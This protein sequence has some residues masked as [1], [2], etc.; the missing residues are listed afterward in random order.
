MEEIAVPTVVCPID[1]HLKKVR[2]KGFAKDCEG[3]LLWGGM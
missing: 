3:D 1:H 2:E